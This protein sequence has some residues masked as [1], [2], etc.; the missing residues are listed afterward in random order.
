MRETIISYLDDVIMMRITMIEEEEDRQ[1]PTA[2]A[3][4]TIS[5]NHN[6]VGTWDT[7]NRNRIG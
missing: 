7:L 1:I 3:A 5:K 2:G 4:P 6:Q